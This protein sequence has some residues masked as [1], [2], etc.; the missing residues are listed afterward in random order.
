MGQIIKDEK[1]IEIINDEKVKITN[2][3]IEEMD[4]TEFYLDYNKK[5]NTLDG[6]VKNDE[7]YLSMLKEG[8]A[9]ERKSLRDQLDLMKPYIP[10]I[11]GIRK[12][13]QD[14]MKVDRDYDKVGV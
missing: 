4:V 14:K 5:K 2:T 11:S 13:Q 6:K 8:Q 12:R 10:Q 3:I 9:N 7:N 1:I